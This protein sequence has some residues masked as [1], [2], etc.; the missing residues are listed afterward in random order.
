MRLISAAQIDGALTYPALIEALAW[1]FRGE[2]DAPRRHH[3]RIAQPGA[4][5]TLLLMPA[6]TTH[7]GQAERFLG[8][9]MVTVFPDNAG[10]GAPAV[11]GSYLLM[12]GATGRPLAIMD[13]RPL[14][15]WR[16]AAASALAASFLA[17]EDASHLVMLGAGVLAPHLVRA[18]ACVRPIRRVTLWNRTR[19]RAV[20]TAFGLATT[21]IEIDVV[22]DR[23]AAVRE[24][25]I[26]CCATLAH[27]PL[28]DGRWLRKGAHVDLVGGYTPAMRE[29][30][31]HALRRA[32]I[33]VDTRAGALKEAGDIIQPLKR[34]VIGKD[35]IR[36]DLFDLCRG[37]V[38][39]RSAAAQITLFKSVGCAIEDL[40]AAAQVWKALAS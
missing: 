31:D 29:A 21:G 2:I 39:G 19:A 17:R 12:S 38:K 3:H 18:H 37:T 13:A 15:A 27:E 5:A 36:G 34:K 33:Y 35:D 25:D 24:A 14:T 40:A 20:A 8:C 9:K 7:T 30:D 11:D 22:D 10:V 6:W 4:D 1:A 23:A 32:R 26:V 28:I 16:T